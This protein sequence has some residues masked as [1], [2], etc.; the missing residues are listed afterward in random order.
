[1]SRTDVLRQG[2]LAAALALPLYCLAAPAGADAAL[3]AQAE[4]A[5]EEEV[6]GF[7]IPAAPAQLE[8]ARGGAETVRTDMKVTG[9][10]N[11][12]SA[13]NVLTGGN[14]IQ[15][16]SFAGASGFPVVIQNT[17]ANVLIQNAT[18]IN[19]QFK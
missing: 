11:G 9:T 13:T 1:M 16:G 5:G 2:A 17:G 7:G 3:A 6:A 10:V 18:V 15:G 8:A 4:T 14:T 12:N 19:I